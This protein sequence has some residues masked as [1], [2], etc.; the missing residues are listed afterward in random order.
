MTRTNVMS[1]YVWIQLAY[2]NFQLPEKN[3]KDEVKQYTQTNKKI[4]S[5]F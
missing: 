3:I 4:R 2:V 5:T 1:D